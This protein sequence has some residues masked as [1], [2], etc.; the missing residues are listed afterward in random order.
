MSAR[1]SDLS[2]SLTPSLAHHSFSSFLT[3]PLSSEP[4]LW[5]FSKKSLINV[6][7]NLV[8]QT[9]N[10]CFANIIFCHHNEYFAWKISLFSASSL[11]CVMQL[12]ECSAH[13]KRQ[14]KLICDSW[15]QTFN[16][17]ESL[18]QSSLKSFAPRLQLFNVRDPL[19]GHLDTKSS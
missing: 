13:G 12:A 14:I 16:R 17:L 7:H 11:P 18:M 2:L 1:Y 8:M 10:V 15:N 9:M 6:H 19:L 5:K 3:N 4:I